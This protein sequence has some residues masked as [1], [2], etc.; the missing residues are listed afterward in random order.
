MPPGTPSKD[1]CRTI[2]NCT[3]SY[4][5]ISPAANSVHSAAEVIQ[6]PGHMR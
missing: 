6:C 2:L 5:S 1:I 3:E 4:R